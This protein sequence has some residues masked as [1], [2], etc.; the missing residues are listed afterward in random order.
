[1]IKTLFSIFFTKA[2]TA[3]VQLY[4]LNKSYTMATRN[5][6][7]RS[8]SVKI[9][10]PKPNE[11]KRKIIKLETAKPEK[12][13]KKQ[14][15][16]DKQP[17]IKSEIDFDTLT[18]EKPLKMG[19]K[20]IGA[21][22]SIAGGLEK[23]VFDAVKMSAKSFGLFLRSQRQWKCKPMEDKAVVTFKKACIDNDFSSNFILPHGSYLLN[24]GA[25]N[26]E[27]LLK[28]RDTLV[29]ELQR[30][31]RL[32]LT[33]YNFHPGSSCVIENMC[34]QG[35]TI[36]GDFNELKAIINLV[37]DKSRIGVCIDTC[38]A[39]AAGYD[40]ASE[41]GY[42]S[43]MFDFDSM[44]GFEYLKGLHFND[45]KGKVGSHLDR[46]ENIGKGFIGVKGFKR[47]MNDVRF[48]N[49]PIILETPWISDDINA[50]EIS[51]LYSL[52]EFDPSKVVSLNFHQKYQIPS[53]KFL[54]NTK[55]TQFYT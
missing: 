17:K 29:D 16:D 45:S 22:T 24:C 7:S 47:F 3:H 11:K 38:H 53:Q 40:L 50:K 13:S 9:I 34:R 26:E 49:M 10:S 27:T 19:D 55:P 20:F 35:N 21:H 41:E 4:V 36:G 2:T 37:R 23:S 5:L 14:R 31:E 44:I 48:N 32:G 33:L 42:Q 8:T 25:P 18:I 15:I 30:C 1:M 6:R 51:L 28:S 39:F 52:F 54:C 12:P 43:M 46:H